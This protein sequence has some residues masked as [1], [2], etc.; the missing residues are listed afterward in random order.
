MKRYLNKKTVYII[1]LIFALFISYMASLS[2]RAVEEF[3]SY[4]KAMNIEAPLT[5]KRF[6]F[7]FNKEL[8]YEKEKFLAKKPLE[9]KESPLPTF[10][11]TV[12]QKD[13]ESL[14]ENLPKSGKDHFIK[15]Y[16]KISD[17][18]K[19]RKIEF[20]YRGDNN[21]HWL[22]PQKSLRIKLLGDDIFNME[23]SFNLINPPNWYSFRDVVVYEFAKEL[24]LMSPDFFPVR[25]FINGKFMGVY[26]Y[27]SQI[28]E[29]LLRKFKR[30]PG[31]IYYGDYGEPDEN[32][33]STL[34]RDPNNWVKKAARNAEQKYDRSDINYLIYAVNH[35]NEKEFYDFFNEM[36]NKDKFYTF[37][38]LD[39][40]FG[41]NHHDFHHNHK[42]YFDPYLGRYEPFEWDLRMWSDERVKDLSVYPLLNRVRLNPIL[43]AERDKRAYEILKS[44]NF[45]PEKIIKRYKEV[46]KKIKRDLESDYLKDTAIL[47]PEIFNDWVSVPFSMD[48][49]EKGIKEDGEI[50]KR[51]FAFLKEL[52]DDTK[53]SY[54]MEGDKIIFKVF[55]NSPVVI[56]VKN[57]EKILYPGRK[58][59]KNAQN[60]R[61]KLLYGTDLIVNSPMFY[62][63]N[64]TDIDINNLKAYNYITKK[65]LTV[66]KE[67]FKKEKLSNSPDLSIFNK[68]PKK[69]IVLKGILDIN[70][71]KIFRDDV[72]IEEGTIFRLNANVSLYF[73]GDLEINGTKKNPVIFKPLFEA[74]PWGIVAVWSKKA[75]IRF[76]KI[77]GGSVDERNL[78]HFTA[79]FSF[80]N[81]K[82]L[83]ISNIT[84]LKN[85]KGDDAMHIAYSNAQVQNSLFKN[86]RSDGLDIDI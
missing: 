85:Y 28:D 53:I 8:K 64:K 58:V 56:K 81:V 45:S 30:M 82:D 42:I 2:I 62:E 15:G 52:Y 32:G 14:N 37:F 24:G 5:M 84:I 1:I 68:K 79:P 61:P 51:R 70:E 46:T 11:I 49:F 20:R 27:L 72:F 83:N 71:T 12:K 9:D 23:K 26:L 69:R 31:S 48:E 40:I 19:V 21:F 41:S 38:A 67:E 33:V 36:I 16:L 60:S 59:L 43:E 54:K 4:K 47:N 75:K 35:L 3:Y 22:Y 10:R 44:L 39:V 6:L 77:R 7:F 18:P 63:F 55:G 78:V 57:K 73:L 17:D 29:S 66:Y 80:H 34:W 13:L 86:A 50:L 76:T 25:V 65:A 74:K